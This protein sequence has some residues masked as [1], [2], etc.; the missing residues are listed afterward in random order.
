MRAD[1]AGGVNMLTVYDVPISNRLWLGTAQYPSLAV[2]CEAIRAA[3]VEVITVS[4]KRQTAAVSPD[5]VTDF[6]QTIRQL[7]CR[8]LP[9]TAGC[10]TAREAV[11]MAEMAA[12]L[13]ETKWIK[14]EVIGDEYTLQPDPF[15][16]L[17]A[18]KILLNQGFEVFP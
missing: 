15:E 12:E 14:L 17:E 1:D 4:L 13:C 10:R 3:R 18:A 5:H 16:L 6:W 11:M 8:I 7:N 9:N 2:M